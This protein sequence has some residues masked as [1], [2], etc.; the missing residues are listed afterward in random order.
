MCQRGGGGYFRRPSPSVGHAHV[1]CSRFSGGGIEGRR[2]GQQKCVIYVA[3]GVHSASLFP[4]RP[5]RLSSISPI[6]VFDPPPLSF[7]GRTCQREKAAEESLF[8]IAPLSAPPSI[9]FCAFPSLPVRRLSDGESPT[10]AKVSTFP[11]L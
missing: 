7:C 2:K 3:G 5:T 11:K 1:R 6:R 8:S 9:S 4:T 10:I